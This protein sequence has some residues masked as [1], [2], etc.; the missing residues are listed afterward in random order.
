MGCYPCN[1]IPLPRQYPSDIVANLQPDTSSGTHWVGIYVVNPLKVYYFDPLGY[2]A[3]KC[4][5]EDFFKKYNFNNI[6]YNKCKIQPLF[7]SYCGLYVIVFHYYM[8]KGFSF[9]NFLTYLSKV[10]IPDLFVLNF[11]NKII[12][13][14][15]LHVYHM[16]V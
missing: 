16:R 5:I 14:C 4:I 7:S 13:Y 6:K 1:R 12:F 2:A 8:C 10:K 15:T 9:D 3:N 11:A